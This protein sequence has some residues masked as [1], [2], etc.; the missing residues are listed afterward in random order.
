L[1]RFV[2]P[3]KYDKLDFKIFNI[4][5]E[6]TTMNSKADQ[7]VVCFNNSF[8]CSQAVFS[9]YC[10]SLGLDPTIALKIAC[11]FGAGMGYTGETCGAVTGA[12]M[13][14]GLKYGKTRPEDNQ[15]KEKTYALAQEFVKRFRAIHGSVKCKE[16]LPYDISIPEELN[17]ARAEGLF[18]TVCPKL[19]Q[20]A[21]EIIEEIL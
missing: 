13:L 6:K 21:A 14:I 11:A 12:L 1:K 2:S 15:A 17:K 19:V 3:L 10:E 7:A 18:T 8:N 16:L 5:R 9:T 4:Q 20:S